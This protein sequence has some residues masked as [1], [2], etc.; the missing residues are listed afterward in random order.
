MKRVLSLSL[1]LVLFA[2]SGAI[3]LKG[4]GR[5]DAR[6]QTK[7]GD[8]NT[9]RD[10]RAR[11]MRAALALADRIG[12]G[13]G[14]GAEDLE[15]MLV[16][17]GAKIPWS[18][19]QGLGALVGEARA[20][21]AYRTKED[22]EPGDVVLFH[23]QWDANGNGAADDWLTGCGVVVERTGRRLFAVVRTGHA[24][25]RIALRP[26]GPGRRI[27]NGKKVNDYLRIPTRSDPKDATYLAGQLYAGHID[28]E[29]LAAG[30]AD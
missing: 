12:G 21:R 9:D 8:A 15:A 26:D 6:D 28:I 23:N 29:A 24:P 13:S 18:A 4:I 14:Y 22:A 7:Q 19:A 10:L 25:R 20:H 30:A 17:A 5:P 2:C 3:N 11:M 27:V 1:V 16:A